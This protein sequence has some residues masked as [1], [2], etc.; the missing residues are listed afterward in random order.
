MDKLNHRYEYI[1]KN[2]IQDRRRIQCVNTNR[3]L[4]NIY[5]LW[6]L[7]TQVDIFFFFCYA[8]TMTRKPRNSATPTIFFFLSISVING[9]FFFNSSIFF[10]RCLSSLKGGGGKFLTSTHITAANIIKRMTKKSLQL[11]SKSL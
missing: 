1:E 8:I 5:T 9:F 4:L 10:Y 3:V 7:K 6:M 11:Y 2:S